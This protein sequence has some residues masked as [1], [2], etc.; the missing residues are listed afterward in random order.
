MNVLTP[1]QRVMV[2]KEVVVFLAGSIEMGAAKEWQQQAIDMFHAIIPEEQRSNYIILNPRRPD[3]DSSWKQVYED[4]QFYQQVTWE[5]NGLRKAG[6]VIVYFDPA[7]KAP[8]S[9][10]ELGAFHEKAIVVCPDG[11][12]RKGNVDIFCEAFN[13]KQVTDLRSAVEFICK[14][15]LE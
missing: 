8:I 9:L 10:L 12:W 4:P 15:T 1:P 3:W 6:F 2:N 14:S 11:F 13:V 7:T 5:L